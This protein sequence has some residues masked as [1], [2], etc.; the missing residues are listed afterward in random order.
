MGLMPRGLY[1]RLV[2]IVS[3]IIIVGI[4]IHGV[5]NFRTQSRRSEDAI[6]QNALLMAKNLSLSCAD[7][8][9][10]NDYGGMEIFLKR[11]AEFTDILGIQVY[12]SKG[13]VLSDIVHERGSP[14]K[15][16]FDSAPLKITE[17]LQETVQIKDDQM[18]VLQPIVAGGTLG[19]VKVNY[20]M[21]EI[22]EMR[23]II[24]RN[25]I[26]LGVIGIII[27]IIALLIALRPP[28]HSIKRIADF[29]RRLDEIK[30]ETIPLERSSVEIEQLCS[31]LNYASQE[32]HSTERA[33]ISEKEHYQMLHDIAIELNRTIDINEILSM[34]LCFSRD[35]LKAETATIALY[36]DSGKIKKLIKRGKDTSIERG[37]LDSKG[38]LR[39]MQYSLTPIRIS[40]IE[41]HPVFSDESF[42]GHPLIRNFLGFPLFSSKGIPI[43]SLFLANKFEGNFTEEDE[44]LLKAIAADASIVIERGLSTEELERFKRIIDG[45]FDIVTITDREGNIIYVNKAFESVTGYEKDFLLGKKLNVISSSLHD[46]VFYENLWKKI[47]QGLPWR[48]ELINRKKDGELFIVSTIIFPVISSDGFITHFVA[49]QRDITEEKKLYEQLL[50]A[51]KMEAIGTLAGGI[52]HDFNNILTSVLGYAELLKSSLSQES[53]LFRYSD[54]IEKSAKRGSDLSK[55]ILSITRKERLEFKPVNL[56]SVVMETVELLKRS[57]PKEIELDLKLEEGI[58]NIK[59]DYSQISQVILNLAINARDAMPQGGR[60]FIGTSIVGSENGAANGLR[61]EKGI[62]FVKLAVEDTGIGVPK[63]YHRKIFD[64]FFTTKDFGKGTG[65]GLYIVHSIVT[66]HGGYINFYS[67]P[68]KGTR[69]NVYFPVYLGKIE[70]GVHEDVLMGKGETVLVIDDEMYICDLYSDVLSKAGYKVIRT[71]DA[72]EGVRIFKENPEIN[73]V[74]LDIVMP[75]MNGREVFQI[76]TQLNPEVKVILSSGYSKDIFADIDRMINSGA[77]AF[78]QKPVSPKTLL[79]TISNVLKQ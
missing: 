74:I 35:M 71:T 14:P 23:Q 29:A 65:L 45:A 55:K 7:Y 3:S 64:P 69:I 22:A 20:S 47:T 66:N 17:P 59:A 2:L 48:G 76:L 1:G 62:N 25:S 5:V 57:I 77:K 15:P 78:M 50:R 30:G 56:N 73:I 54:I 63:E 28:V 37:P 12:D 53:E 75:Q 38:I 24:W 60:L 26:I 10:V 8:L 34:I 41:N 27:S 51:Q 79:A 58:P 32:L 49:I 52:A 44:T 39:L 9:I 16:R 36:D 13:Q 21:T 18:I 31:A 11:F 67:E 61:P 43:G 6:K 70:E 33:L 40:D 68:N 46:K 42:E 19:W 4:L 72:R